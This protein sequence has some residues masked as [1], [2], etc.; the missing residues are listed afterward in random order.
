MNGIAF[1]SYMPALFGFLLSFF[2]GWKRL[3]VTLPLWSV[4]GYFILFYS[5]THEG[6]RYR[7]PVDPYI[8]LLAIFTFLY[9]YAKVKKEPFPQKS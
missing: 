6:L 1:I 9:L 8:I 3:Y 7:L 2:V 5:L 4:V